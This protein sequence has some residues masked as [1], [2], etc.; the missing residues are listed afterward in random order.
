MKEM[1]L[2]RKRDNQK[3]KLFQINFQ[4]NYGLFCC[5]RQYIFRK[6][7][8][9]KSK[10]VLNTLVINSL[11]GHLFVFSLFLFSNMCNNSMYKHLNMQTNEFIFCMCESKCVCV[12]IGGRGAYRSI[13]STHLTFIFIRC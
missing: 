12:W 3:S 4:R 13:T 10:L 6:K 5:L 2:E 9:I 7:I 1:E 8:L 11:N